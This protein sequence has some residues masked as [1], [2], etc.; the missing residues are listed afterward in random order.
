MAIVGYVLS[1]K[2]YEKSIN[3][4]HLKG[5][6]LVIKIESKQSRAKFTGNNRRGDFNSC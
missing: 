6:I 3:V 2:C 1:N 4:V 5:N